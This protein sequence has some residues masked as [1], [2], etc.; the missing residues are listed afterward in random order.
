MCSKGGMEQSIHVAHNITNAKDR[1]Q[2]NIAPRRMAERSA[3]FSTADENG[4]LG[5]TTS[6]KK[7]I[8][9][10]IWRTLRADGSTLLKCEPH[11]LSNDSVPPL[12][13]STSTSAHHR[14]VLHVQRDSCYRSTETE[15][16]V[17]RKERWQ[18]RQAF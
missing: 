16:E 18:I 2:G 7:N 4:A 10:S 13:P 14:T 11:F 1:K 6:G 9:E 5:Q 12:L 17:E 8:S 3:Q 15:N